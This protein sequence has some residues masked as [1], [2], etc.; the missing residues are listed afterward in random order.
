MKKKS[1]L[2]I[3]LAML[4][5]VVLTG[6]TAIVTDDYGE[7]YEIPLDDA[8]EM[9]REY[10]AEQMQTYI[11]DELAKGNSLADILGISEAELE[12]IIRQE[13]RSAIQEELG[14][15]DLDL[16]GTD[17]LGLLMGGD[18]ESLFTE[19]NKAAVEKKADEVKEKAGQA[20]EEI[21]K[22]SRGSR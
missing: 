10:I 12:Q 6:C 14:N 19:E 3:L 15:Q 5:A 11:S 7:T 2:F 13:I 22:K 17:I 9:A 8:E 20:A 1:F 16:S 4:T 18:L 21:E